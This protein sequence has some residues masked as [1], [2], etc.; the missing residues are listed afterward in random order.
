MNEISQNPKSET[1]PSQPNKFDH[2]KPYITRLLE[3]ISLATDAVRTEAPE[4]ADNELFVV[5]YE[6]SLA[7]AGQ[8]IGAAFV[9]NPKIDQAAY[10]RSA[11]KSLQIHTQRYQEFFLLGQEKQVEDKAK[12]EELRQAVSARGKAQQAVGLSRE[13]LLQA[14]KK[15]AGLGAVATAA[16]GAMKEFT[17]NSAHASK[18]VKEQILP[19]S[20]TSAT[21]GPLTAQRFEEHMKGFDLDKCMGKSLMEQ[22]KLDK[23]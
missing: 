9:H 21:G 13:Q 15:S 11:A 3:K 6:A 16:A 23:T 10:F 18:V 20:K 8:V 22:G 5:L 7:L 4:L 17:E 14:M 2:L 19:S 1:T 12:T